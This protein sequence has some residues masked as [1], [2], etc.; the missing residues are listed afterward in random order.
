MSGHRLSALGYQPGKFPAKTFCPQPRADN[1][2]QV[3]YDR[4]TPATC[5]EH[6]VGDCHCGRSDRA[7]VGAAAARTAGPWSMDCADRPAAVGCAAD[8]FRVAA[9]DVCLHED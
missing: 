4:T 3:S 7:V 1:R 6:V 5:R 2:Q 8:T 9:A